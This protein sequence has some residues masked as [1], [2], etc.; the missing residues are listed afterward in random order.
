M[1][2]GFLLTEEER[3][4]KAKEKENDMK[5]QKIQAAVNKAKAA[6]AK[7]QAVGQGVAPQAQAA[8][9]KAKAKQNRTSVQGTRSEDG[10]TVT[11]THLLQVDPTAGPGL[12]GAQ[13]GVQMPQWR[14][15]EDP[16]DRED[17]NLPQGTRVIECGARMTGPGYQVVVYRAVASNDPLEFEMQQLMHLPAMIE[18]RR[19]FRIRFILRNP[20]DTP[21]DAVMMIPMNTNNTTNNTTATA[22]TSGA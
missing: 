5:R 17:R 8:Q 13:A 14:E 4:R 16:W 12:I 19:H 11:T 1:N 10:A 22:P 21:Y 2:K 6:Q 9:A 3:G 20:E 7:Q 15:F 18:L